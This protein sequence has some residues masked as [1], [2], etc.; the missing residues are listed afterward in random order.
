M[1]NFKEV[2]T[3]KKLRTTGLNFKLLEVILSEMLIK[4][5]FRLLSINFALTNKIK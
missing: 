2:T 1:F 3:Q 5:T 4:L